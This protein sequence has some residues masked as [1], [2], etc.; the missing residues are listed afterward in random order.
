MSNSWPIK[1][2]IPLLLGLFIVSY[3]FWQLRHV[4]SGPNLS[5]ITPTS[6]SIL[7]EPII[8]VV[9]QASGIDWLYLNGRQIFTDQTGKFNESLLASPGLNVLQLAGIDKFGR[10]TEKMLEFV[11][12]SQQQQHDQET[13]D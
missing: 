3:S 2:T 11:I 9:G 1:Y 7:G 13:E 10:R 12:N 4:V 5:V 8:K 6:G